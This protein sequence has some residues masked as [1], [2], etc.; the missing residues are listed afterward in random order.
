MNNNVEYDYADELR[1]EVS[2]NGEVP[3]FKGLAWAAGIMAVLGLV[4]CWTMGWP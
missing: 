4:F 2:A 1:G 3:F